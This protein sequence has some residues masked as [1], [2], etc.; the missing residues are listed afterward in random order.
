MSIQFT[1]SAHFYEIQEILGESHSST[2]YLAQRFDKK[3]KIKQPVVIKL[4]KHKK[5]PEPALQMESL[6][7]ARHSTHL[8]KVLSFERFQS[9]PALILEHICGVNLKQLVKNTD[10]SQ[11]EIACICS[12][13]F[14]GLKELKRSGLAHGDLSLSNVLIDIKGQIYLTDYGL[15]NY[16]KNIFYSTK[17]FTA[18]ELY[19][20]K[21]SCL[22]SDL[23][24]LGVL[25]KILS[26]HFIQEELSSMENTHF[27]CKGDPLLDPLPQ[28]RR[29]KDFVFSSDTR[30]FL[31]D[32]VHQSLFIKNCFNSGTIYNRPPLPN[33]KKQFSYRNISLV[34]IFL[35]LLFTTNPF[36]SYGKY[37]PAEV[38]IRTEKWVYIQMAG[39]TGY[40]PVN[41]HIKKPGTYE[42][43]WKK[44]NK[45]GSKHI[46]LR[47]GQKITLRDNDFP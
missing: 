35:L 43:K 44:K 26:G 4:F 38:L 23:F 24:S 30:A 9:H 28:N 36:I 20:G 17:P 22:Q 27:I 15:A 11:N 3:F 18:P 41:I 29:K 45:S 8:I 47:S 19:E 14:T 21:P 7:R 39:F 2:V 33:T 16:E 37:A 42:L 46:H 12:Q 1:T 32:K 25:E 40:S 13:V 5:S 34:G 6:L 31:S 10:F